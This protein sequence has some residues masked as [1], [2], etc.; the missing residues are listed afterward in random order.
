MARP[1]RRVDTW[2]TKRW[3]K[4]VAPSIF[5]EK[6]IGVTPASEVNQILGRTV[7][8]DLYS[9]T[10]KRELQHV[11]VIFRINDLEGETG[12]T[13]PVGQRLQRAYTGRL[14]RRM[15][16]IVKAI[17]TVMTKD[18]YKVQL[19]AMALS[20]GKAKQSQ[21]REIRRI[22]TEK[23]A[24]FADKPFDKFFQDIV[25]GKLAGDI[26]K[27]VK[28]IFPIN[29]VEIEKTEVLEIPGK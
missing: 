22:M 18:G 12:K 5:G 27:S 29:R 4:I 11:K 1:K 2:K 23:I 17:T 21:K 13:I 14:T 6:E 20:R 10:G 28:K 3:F 15:H 9:L 16:T 25:Y 8:M 7:E 19:T 26:F 24:E